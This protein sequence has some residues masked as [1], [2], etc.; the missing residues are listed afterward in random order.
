VSAVVERGRTQDPAEE[1]MTGPARRDTATGF[2]AGYPGL[3]VS[4]YR[5]RV[6]E[7]APNLATDG[8]EPDRQES[9]GGQVRLVSLA[10]SQYGVTIGQSIGGHFVIGS[11]LKLVKA[12]MTV[13]TAEAAGD[14][15][16]R[17]ADADVSTDTVADIDLGVMA[18]MGRFRLGANVKHVREPEIG[19]GEER[20]QLTRQARAGAAYFV[21]TAGRVESLAFSAD[22]DLTRTATVLGDIRRF[23][24]GLE[25]WSTGR[26]FGVRTGFN[27]NTLDSSE[28]TGSVGATVAGPAGVAVDVAVLFGPDTSRNGL[29]TGL[30]MTF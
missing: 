27:M 1:G 17:A 6:S 16:D 12:G 22:L 8:Q 15:L 9:E 20:I 23:G 28:K 19:K 14:L 21:P 29:A 3:V 7:I 25:I 10:L 18:M 5:F 26:R 24:A 30:R 11:T 13:S 2:S 4:Y